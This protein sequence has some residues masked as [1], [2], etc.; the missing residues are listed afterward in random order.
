MIGPGEETGGRDGLTG[1]GKEPRLIGGYIQ[2]GRGCADAT[3]WKIGRLLDGADSLSL[4]GTIS[5]LLDSQFLVERFP[6]LL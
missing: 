6:L 3:I 4:F 1:K 2:A 5:H